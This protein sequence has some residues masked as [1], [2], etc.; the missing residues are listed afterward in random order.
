MPISTRDQAL[1]K[2]DTYGSMEVYEQLLSKRRYDAESERSGRRDNQT[3]TGD[4][5]IR[6]PD[7][8]NDR[9]HHPRYISRDWESERIP[10]RLNLGNDVDDNNRSRLKYDR[11]VQDTRSERH[12]PRPERYLA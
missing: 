12:N 4:P 2:K 11:D 1:P 5:Y 7:V 9:M 6:R 3:E 10:L 8:D